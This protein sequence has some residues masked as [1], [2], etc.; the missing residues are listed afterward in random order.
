MLCARREQWLTP[1]VDDL[2]ARGFTAEECRCDVSNP[3]DVQTLVER[4]LDRYGH[5]DILVNNAGVS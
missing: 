2:R 5:I 1:A 4:T 3:E